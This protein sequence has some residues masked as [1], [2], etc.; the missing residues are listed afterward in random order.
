ME[1]ALTAG[2]ELDYFWDSTYVN[3]ILKLQAYNEQKRLD[4]MY[5]AS[6]SYILAQMI[7]ANVGALFSKDAKVPPIQKF[8]PHLFDEPINEEPVEKGKLTKTEMSFLHRMIEEK[9]RR[10]E[11]EKQQQKDKE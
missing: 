9:N 2:I 6:E 1:Q 7:G 11:L 3:I 10:M 8:Y 5:R 4:S